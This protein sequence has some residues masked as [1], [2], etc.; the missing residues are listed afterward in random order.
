MVNKMTF[1]TAIDVA[2][3]PIQATFNDYVFFIGSCFADNISEKMEMAILPTYSNPFGTAYNPQTIALQID[4]IIDE[5]PCEPYEIKEI[6]GRWYSMMAHSKITST[7]KDDL[8]KQICTTTDEAHEYLHKASILVITFGTAWV[9]KMKNS[10]MIVANCHKLPS[11]EFDRYRLT[12]DEIV[13]IWIN[14]INKIKQFNPKVKII[15]TISPIRHLKDT[16]HGNQLSKAELI[17]SIDKLQKYF[18]EDSIEYFPAYE[19]LLDDLRDYRFYAEDMVHPSQ[20]AIDYIFEKFIS[21][22][23]TEATIR[24][25]NETYKISQAMAHHQIGSEKN[26]NDFMK[27]TLDKAN[28]IIQKYNIDIKANNKLSEILTIINKQIK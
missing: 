2:K 27:A 8:I 16:A 5:D 6:D 17:T 13:E 19:L 24:Y 22:Y 11:N 7:T 18:G 10:Q 1:R 4:R 12:S 23:Y 20:T 14:L 28:A 26:Y 3:S 25:I 15:F 21:T 9:F